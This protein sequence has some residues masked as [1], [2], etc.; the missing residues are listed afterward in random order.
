M[1][2]IAPTIVGTHGMQI[3]ASDKLKGIRENCSLRVRGKKN[4]PGFLINFPQRQAFRI[5]D[6]YL[7][8]FLQVSWKPILKDWKYHDVVRR[9]IIKVCENVSITVRQSGNVAVVFQW[10][11]N[12]DELG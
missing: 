5:C 1:S 10:C 2:C 3:E 8:L 6:I 4:L 11:P 12:T 7:I 9:S